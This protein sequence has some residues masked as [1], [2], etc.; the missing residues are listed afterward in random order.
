MRSMFG[1]AET[2][3]PCLWAAVPVSIQEQAADTEVTS[4]GQGQL[5]FLDDL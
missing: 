5:H 2:R 4:R 1:N 3:G